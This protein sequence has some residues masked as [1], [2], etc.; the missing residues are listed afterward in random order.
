MSAKELHTTL[1]DQPPEVI[2]AVEEITTY[3][4]GQNPNCTPDAVLERILKHRERAGWN[5]VSEAAQSLL[6]RERIESAR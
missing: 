2:E 1:A 6:T 5:T 4:R 3:T